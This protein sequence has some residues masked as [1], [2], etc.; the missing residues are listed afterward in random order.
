MF[1]PLYVVQVK[2]R[3]GSHMIVPLIQSYLHE[4]YSQHVCIY[5]D[6]YA[7]AITADSGVCIESINK[8]YCGAII[9]CARVCSR[10]IT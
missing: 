2:R 3:T 6:W 7:T 8:R 5:A 10:V 4:H 1:W 9:G